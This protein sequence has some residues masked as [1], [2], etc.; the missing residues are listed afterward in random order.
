ML[1]PAALHGESFGV[2]LHEAM[3]AGTPV[4]A[5]DIPGYRDVARQEKEAVLVPGGD[6]A[7]LAGGLR[8][9]LDDATLAARLVEAGTARAA[10]FSMER[11]AAR[12]ADLYETLLART[13]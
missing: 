7:A 9:V 1:R 12:Y 11:L 6:P 2:I 13:P 5:S 3:A 8:R 4:V 10:G